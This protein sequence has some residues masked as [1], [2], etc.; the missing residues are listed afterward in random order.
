MAFPKI[1]T[2]KNS[3]PIKKQVNGRVLHFC[4][5]FKSVSSDT[6]ITSE[7][8]TYFLPD[9]RGTSAGNLKMCRAFSFLLKA[10]S[11]KNQ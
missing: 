2:I 1:P 3:T 10:E 11:G 6:V 5:N 8:I 9:N 7:K 4:L